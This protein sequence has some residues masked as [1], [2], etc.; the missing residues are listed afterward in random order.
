MPIEEL[1]WRGNINSPSN[2]LLTAE[3][4][5]EVLDLGLSVFKNKK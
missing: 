2:K 4:V 3:K 1:Q 5:G